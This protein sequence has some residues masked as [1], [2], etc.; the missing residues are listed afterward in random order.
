VLGYVFVHVKKEYSSDIADLNNFKKNINKLIILK[1]RWDKKS[2][3]VNL[4]SRFK[5][6]GKDFS[7][8]T[9]GNI[10]TL[11]FKNL[12]Q[13]SLKRVILL[14]F[15]SYLHIK[16]VVVKSENN[17]VSMHIEVKI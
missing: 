16:K 12:D 15:N 2:N 8:S 13:K 4:K 17:T 11:S 14:I 10:E 9:K 5:K 3:T 7:Y 6:L 1:Q